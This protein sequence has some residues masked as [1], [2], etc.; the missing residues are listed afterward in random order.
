[1]PPAGSIRTLS[2]HQSELPHHHRGRPRWRT[3]LALVVV[4]LGLHLM[5]LGGSE[6]GAAPMGRSTMQ[7]VPVEVRTLAPAPVVQAPVVLVPA[8]VEAMPVAAAP[9]VPVKPRPVVLAA[10]AT[11]A[12]VVA[13]A[14]PTPPPVAPPQEPAAPSQ[15]LAL[16]AEVAAKQESPAAGDIEVPT[17]RTQLPPATTLRYDLRRGFLS[18]TGELQWKPG[19]GQ[20]ELRLEGHV[21]GL[22]ILVQTSQ[23]LIDEAGLAPVRYVD[24]RLRDTRAANFQ[25]DKGRITFSGPAVEFPLLPGSQDRL[26]WMVQLGAILNAEPQRAASGAKV[27]MFIVGARGDGDV[28]VFRFAGTETVNTALGT[29][30]AVKFTREPR[31]PYDTQVEVWLAPAHSH[32]PVRAKLT[33][34][35]DGSSLELLLREMQ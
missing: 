25:R 2:M 21:G 18:G 35:P 11:A 19:A 33:T 27:A 28:W 34:A 8:A 32:L 26:S 13:V 12:V 9:A 10:S 29:L 3:L 15:D 30:H 14:A 1:M 24:K 7:V 23:G 6:F 20:Y 5:L 17:Y 22:S 16:L 4:T 31:K